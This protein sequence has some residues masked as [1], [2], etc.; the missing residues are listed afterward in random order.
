MRQQKIYDD[1]H[2]ACMPSRSQRK[3]NHVVAYS[4]IHHSFGR[5][6]VEELQVSGKENELKQRGGDHEKHA[7]IRFMISYG[8]ETSVR[9]NL[10]PESTGNEQEPEGVTS[11]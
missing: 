1:F 11:S 7:T 5:R 4:C 10:E 6:N 9:S 3:K 8:S 2:E